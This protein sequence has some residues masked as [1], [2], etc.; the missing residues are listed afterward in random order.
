MWHGQS[1]APILLERHRASA[2][3]PC[4]IQGAN[5]TAPEPLQA[6]ISETH[7]LIRGAETERIELYDLR[8]DPKEQH[9]LCKDHPELAAQLRTELSRW[10]ESFPTRFDVQDLDEEQAEMLQRLRAVGYLG[11]E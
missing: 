5:F 4:P 1:L 10:T 11:D 7:K 6:I 3:R 2:S 8:S 9:D